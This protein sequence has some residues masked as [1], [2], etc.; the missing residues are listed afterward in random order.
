[1][2]SGTVSRACDYCG[3]H[4]GKDIAAPTSTIL[5]SIA[6]T[7]FYYYCEPTDAGVPYE[8]GWIIEP[9]DTEDVLMSIGL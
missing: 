9:T 5:E 1:V 6:E 3:R 7:V 2:H 4:S 8:R